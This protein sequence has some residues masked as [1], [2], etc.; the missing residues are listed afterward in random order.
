MSSE[1][2]LLVGQWREHQLHVYSADCCHVTSIKL[3]D[4]DKVDKVCDAVWTRRGN[5]V[6]GEPDR[7]KVVTMS[8]S[9]DVI[10]Q[11]NVLLLRPNCLSVS[12]DD[13]IFLIGNYTSVYQSTDDGLTWSHMFNVTDGWRCYQVIKVSTDSNTD[14]LWTVVKS[15][16]DWRQRV[17]TVDKLQA[18]GD[19]VTWRDVTLPS[20]VTKNLSNNGLAYDGYTSMG[21]P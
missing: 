13:V 4:N 17:Y 1:G 19:N 16:E 10:Q 14:V 5:I 21:I 3:P 11:T 7:N 8:Q 20:H 15:N 9:G 2:Q 6:Y 12:T 18:V